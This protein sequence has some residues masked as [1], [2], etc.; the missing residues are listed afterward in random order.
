MD[1]KLKLS[2]GL[3]KTLLIWSISSIIVGL[4]LLTYFTPII[5]GIGFQAILWGIIDAVVAALT[6]FK[7]DNQ[8]IGKMTRIL[9]INV[10]LDIIYQL[11]GLFLLLFMWQ[12]AFIVGNGIG[13]IIQ[14]AFLFVLDLYYY[15]QF[16]QLTIE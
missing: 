8:S 15:H 6:L 14:G 3:G 4:I 5:Q 13:V 10:G 9:G 1:I 12:D 11:I 2:Q 7:K 16:K